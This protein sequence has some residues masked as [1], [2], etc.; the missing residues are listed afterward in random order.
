MMVGA[1]TQ[2]D[3]AFHSRRRRSDSN[4]HSRYLRVKIRVVET[5]DELEERVVGAVAA[6]EQINQRKRFGEKKTGRPP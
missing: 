1:L 4:N 3:M 5:V 2:D 6:R